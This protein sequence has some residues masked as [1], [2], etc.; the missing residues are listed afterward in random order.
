MFYYQFNVGAYRTDT[1]HLSILEH[2]V[3]RQL[4]DTYYV[5]ESPLSC[6]MNQ[7]ARLHRIRSED[8]L[9]ALRAVL[10]EF[11]YKTDEG[12]RHS[13]CDKVMAKVYIKSEKARLSAEKKWE[14]DRLN[15]CERIENVCERNA[16]ASNNHANAHKNDANAMLP[17]TCNPIPVTHNTIPNTINHPPTGVVRWSALTC[18]LPA[19][20][21]PA[22]W[23]AW[24]K[25][26]SE[27]KKPIKQ[28]SAKLQWDFLSSYQ[29]DTQLEIVNQSIRNGWHGLFAPKAGNTKQSINDKI[30]DQSRFIPLDADGR[31]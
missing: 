9:A 8:E 3:Y 17:V 6:D 11:F 4:I 31:F 24:C 23:Q 20:I 2:G 16:N 25:Y 22:A 30:S 14:L 5:N 27:A 13:G 18:E 15:K 28:T 10:D 12:Y 29:P 19:S 1:S 21:N 26:K 7:I